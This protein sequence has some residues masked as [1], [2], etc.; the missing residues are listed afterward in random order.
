MMK[1]KSICLMAIVV[2]ANSMAG[3]A[4]GHDPIHIGSITS[5]TDV[6]TALEG[7]RSIVIVD[8]LAYITGQDEDGV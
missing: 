8:N 7:A 1:N 6:N 3:I 4:R 2:I 5:N